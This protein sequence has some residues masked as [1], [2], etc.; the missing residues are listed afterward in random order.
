M[1]QVRQQLL[2]RTHLYK[3][4]DRFVRGV[5]ANVRSTTKIK[6]LEE[7]LW[8]SAARYRAARKALANL[9]QVLNEHAWEATLLPLHPED[10]RGMPRALFHD[11][12]RKKLMMKRGPQA[13][14]RAA[15][16]GR[17]AK[18]K[19][20]WI[21]RAPGVEEGEGSGMHEG[22]SGGHTESPKLI[23][24]KALRIEW[25]KTRARFLRNRS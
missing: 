18:E 7:R 6:G 23:I 11:P 4:K 20:S 8:R 12:E 21:W 3:F 25:A 9:G 22:G 2:L 19:M 10:V 24:S 5:R 16:A 13:R 15:D 1:D 17:Q 14:A